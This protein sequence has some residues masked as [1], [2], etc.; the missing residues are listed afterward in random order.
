M[1]TK[2][3]EY[4]IHQTGDE[5]DTPESSDPGFLDRLFFGCHNRE[6]TINLAVGM[7]IH[8]N[9]NIMDGYVILRHENSHHNLRLSRH[10]QGGDDRTDMRIGPLSIQVLE[11]HKRWA[12][13]L[14][15]NLQ[16][17]NCDLVFEAR[18][19]PYLC[20]K[21][22]METPD[23]G[24]LSHG[25]FFQGGRYNGSITLQGQHFNVDGFLGI[26]DRSWG[27]R[28]WTAADFGHHYW[29][30]V[31]FAHSTLFIIH[32]EMRDGSVV[33]SEGVLTNDDGS[34][35]YITEIRHRAELLPGVRALA[36]VD[37]LLKDAQGGQRCLTARPISPAVYLNG[38]G[39]ARLGEDKGPLSIEGE[40][41]DVSEPV[42][43]DSPRFGITQPVGE[44]QL[45]GELGV[46]V[47]EYS[48]TPQK[49]FKY[50]P[51]F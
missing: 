34:M 2:Y 6:G 41:W 5:M 11:P 24:T 47:M 1:L 27:R 25:H 15:D 43:I 17:I 29:F 18:V 44:F 46:G 42:G 35:I 33:W 22:V 26:R 4:F 20:R 38:G 8:P 50:K 48:F 37:M 14:G 31:H 51:T 13:Q 28:G 21:V 16:G 39:Y 49:D 45:D 12:F 9:R 36:K 23:R 19:P 40:Q 30:Q 3:D 32:M 10:M 7:G